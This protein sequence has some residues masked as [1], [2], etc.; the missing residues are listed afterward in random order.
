MNEFPDDPVSVAYQWGLEHSL[1]REALLLDE[2]E[3]YNLVE[4]IMR[5]YDMHHPDAQLT[6]EQWDDACYCIRDELTD[7]ITNVQNSN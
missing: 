6:D 1:R 5:D 3:R 4:E 2:Q 7:Q